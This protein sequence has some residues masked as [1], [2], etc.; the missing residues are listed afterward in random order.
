MYGPITSWQTAK[1]ECGN[2]TLYSHGLVSGPSFARR[3]PQRSGISVLVLPSV[4]DGNTLLLPSSSSLVI[5]IGTTRVDRRLYSRIEKIRD[6]MQA[7]R[8]ETI[9]RLVEEGAR[10]H[11]LDKAMQLLRDGKVTVSKAAEIAGLSIWDILQEMRIRKTPIPFSG[12]DPRM[13]MEPDR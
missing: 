6:D 13:S 10:D 9:R 5:R 1:G 12:D 3:D 4:D 8:S 11:E 2:Q 7:D